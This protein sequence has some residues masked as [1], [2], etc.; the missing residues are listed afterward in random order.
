VIARFQKEE[1][2]KKAREI[3]RFCLEDFLMFAL[4]NDYKMF[5]SG[6]SKDVIGKLR[7]KVFDSTSGYFLGFMI[8]RIVERQREKLTESREK[9]LREAA[10]KKAD[11]IVKSFENKFRVKDQ[12]THR[13]L[14]RVICE[15]PDWFTEQLRKKREQ[16]PVAA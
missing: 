11:R 16:Q 14:F 13:D 9:H 8:R 15:N 7:R 4:E 12:I 6:S 2:N 10:Q 3:A 1:P 5:L